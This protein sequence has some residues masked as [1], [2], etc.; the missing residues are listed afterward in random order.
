MSFADVLVAAKQLEERAQK[1]YMEAGEKINFILGVSR[2][3]KR[4]SQE[5]AKA[6][7]SIQGLS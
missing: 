1:F 5:R 7:A 2:L 3:Y 4:Y 6:L